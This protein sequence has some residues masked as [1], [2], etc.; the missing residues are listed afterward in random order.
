MSGR[1]CPST[2]VEVWGAPASAVLAMDASAAAGVVGFD[3]WNSHVS[4]SADS[5]CPDTSSAYFR[6]S[7]TVALP[8]A[9]FCGQPFSTAKKASSPISLR[10]ACRARAP[11]S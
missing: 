7:A 9:Y 2:P 6:K 11:R 8:Y 1:S 3:G 10:S 4:K 5:D